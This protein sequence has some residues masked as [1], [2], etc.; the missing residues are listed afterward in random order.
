MYVYT[1]DASPAVYAYMYFNTAMATGLVRAALC[2][3]LTDSSA[4]EVSERS[5]KA[6]E[7]V[8]Y[9][10]T[11]ITE[12][13]F[14]VKFD[15]FAQTLF[16][17]IDN[18]VCTEISS[19]RST[20]AKCVLRERLWSSFHKLRQK[21]L[22]DIWGKF[23][24]MIGKDRLDPLVQHVNQSLFEDMLKTYIQS[25]FEDMLKTYIQPSKQTVTCPEHHLPTLSS[26][27]ENIIRYAA[28]YVPMKL[29]KKYEKQSLDVAVEYVECLNSMAVNGDESSLQAYTL[30]WSRKV[31]RGG[32]FE[33]NDETFRFFREI[34][35]KMQWQL[36]EV[37]RRQVP[38]EGQKQLI[39][40][41]YSSK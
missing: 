8:R 30:E 10:L 13:E 26:D 15:G 17:A 19:S 35:I 29:M 1:E 38:I 27:E 16:T 41:T 39:I 32:L 3:F 18:C 37:L 25:L 4:L 31:N 14:L 9:I 36:M 5:K 22:M 24:E 21:E 12:D 33:V 6:K 11:K 20:R 23:F 7:G 34:E 2:S 40:D 28:G